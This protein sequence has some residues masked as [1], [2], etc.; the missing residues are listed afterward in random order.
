VIEFESPG[1]PRRAPSARLG[2]TLR[3]FRLRIDPAEG[4]LGPYARRGWRRGRP[5][6]QE[7]LAECVGVSRAWYGLLESERP[8]RASIFL[9]D[10]LATALMLSPQE[11]VN[12]FALALP[13][14]KTSLEM[15]IHNPGKPR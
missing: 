14:L 6:T 13:E 8:V 11:R 10:R 4:A 15:S 9:L 5:V 12:L 3:Q 1:T 2:G 7:E